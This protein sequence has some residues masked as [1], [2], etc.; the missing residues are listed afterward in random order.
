MTI[1]PY[2][3][4]TIIT[5][6]VININITMYSMYYQRTALLLTQE[7]PY[8]VMLG[9]PTEYTVSLISCSPILFLLIDA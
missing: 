6:L 4:K 9:Y 5:L 8:T 2:L 7:N 3:L 1:L